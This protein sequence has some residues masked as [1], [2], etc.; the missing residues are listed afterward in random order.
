M[1]TLQLMWNRVATLSKMLEHA[2][3]GCLGHTAIMKLMYFLQVIKKVPLGY[4]FR[5]HYYG[6][7]ESQVIMDITS[8]ENFESV[9]SKLIFYPK[10]YGYEVRRGPE[11]DT[12]ENKAKDFL[13]R[14][15][16]DIVWVT[17]T[18]GIYSASELELI[19]T[20]KYV[21]EEFKQDH[22]RMSLNEFAQ[23]IQSIKTHFDLEYIRSKIQ[24][25]HQQQIIHS[26]HADS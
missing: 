11:A 20:I 17:K 5:L 25:L 26:I 24:D 7:Y 14:Y 3:N 1:D 13:E 10:G 22:E 23:K 12:I 19:S 2:P 15:G 8:A 6:P 18:F 21:D 4:D 9:D 16:N